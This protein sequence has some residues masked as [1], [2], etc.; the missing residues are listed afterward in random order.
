MATD[1]DQDSLRR[2]YQLLQEKQQ[3]RLVRLQQRKAKDTNG[4]SKDQARNQESTDKNSNLPNG[5]S[6]WL[7]GNSLNLKVSI[8]NSFDYY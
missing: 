1:S 7:P 2:Q 6:S 3:Q 4:T 5:Q 8:M